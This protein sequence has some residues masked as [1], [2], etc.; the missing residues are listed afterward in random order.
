MKQAKIDRY[1]A[2]EEILLEKY[3]L[4]R[5]EHFIPVDKLNIKV[6]VQ[7]IGKGEPLL[8]IHGG[9]NAG[10]T[11]LEIASL[12]EGYQ[13]LI[14]D[15]PGCG[16]SDAVSYKNIDL[17]KIVDI[18]SSTIGAVQDHFEISK[19]SILSSSFGSYWAIWYAIRNP[20]RVGKLIM[21]GCP[22]MVEGSRVPDFMKSMS[23]PIVKWLVPKL[24]QTNS[25]SKKMMKKIG[26]TY[27]VENGIIG[28]LFI[29]WYVS[30]MNNTDTL[31]N[32]VGI[33]SQ[34]IKRGNLNPEFMLYDREVEKVTAPA[35]WLWG[36]DDTF[37]GVDI[38]KRLSDLLKE[39]S[40]YTYKNSGH[41]PWLDQPKE[42][43]EKIVEFMKS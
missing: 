7:V 40:I 21:E 41:L 12:L 3:N 28:D 32:D 6:R 25:Y 5:E 8:L 4:K 16:L 24:P 10:S 18:I 20:E 22:A 31:K 2:S 39:S 26:H 30:L 9:P 1:R 42:H 15:R 27:A 11:W 23:N 43:A 14:L 36:E 29:N 34:A 13:C 19:M 17:E 33:I 38:G 35:L 37:G